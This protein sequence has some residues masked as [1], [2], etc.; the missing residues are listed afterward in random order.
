MQAV[1]D[2]YIESMNKPFRNRGYIKGSIGIINSDAQNNAT[3][4]NK[5]NAFTYFSNIKRPFTSYS[6]NQVYATGEQNF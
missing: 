5:Q 4:N 2:A 6:V 3:A 1:S